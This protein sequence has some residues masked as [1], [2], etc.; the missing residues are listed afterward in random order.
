MSRP[1]EPY[2]ERELAFLAGQAQEFG[3]RFPAEAGR[4]LPDTGRVPDPHLERFIEALA[5]VTGRIHHKLD[6]EFPVLTQSLLEVLYPHLTRPVPSMG[7]AQFGVRPEAPPPREGFVVPRH[8]RLQT[9]PLGDPPKAPLVACTWRTGYPVELWP[10]QVT[11]ALVEPRPL[12]SGPLRARAV[13]RVHLECLGGA[14][15]A[16]LPLQRLRFFLSGGD[17]LIASLYE[18]LF[19]HTLRVVIRPPDRTTGG[20]ELKPEECLRPVGFGPDEGLL[21]FDDRSFVGYRLLLEFLSYRPKFL[22]VDVAGWDQV[23]EAKFG[24]K[25]ELLFHLGRRVE[26]LEQGVSA[27]TFLLGCT[28]I[29]NLFRKSA[30][31]IALDH[32]RPEY[33]VV[34]SRAHPQAAEVYSVDSVASLDGRLQLKEFHPFYA[35]DV[36]ATRENR[37]TFWH[38][39]RRPSETEGDAGTEVNLVVTDRDWHPREP[40]DAVLH[41]DTTSS[42]RDYPARFLRGRAPLTCEAGAPEPP[43]PVYSLFSPSAPLRPALGRSAHWRLVTQLALNHASLADPEQGLAALRETFRLCSFTHPGLEPT[44]DAVNRQLIDGMTA[45]RARRALAQVASE[46]IGFCRGLDFFLE[47]DEK[48]YVGVGLALFAAVL[49]R[50]LGLCAAVNSFSRLNVSVPQGDFSKQWPPRSAYQQLR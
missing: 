42:N 39:V 17:A 46:G 40:A 37:R 7:V 22:F 29:V 21:P 28:P 43:G 13:L 41:V 2:Y 38:A 26:T 33:H 23:R 16:E 49:D 32:H 25:V 12:A 11:R 24:D 47:L 5:L 14:T 4:M 15:F 48:K 1:L 34:P 31:P 18:A 44:R 10:L 6:N 20:V 27:Q 8:A 35:Y 30:E 9:P 3:R 19:H 36:G 50:Y 45:L